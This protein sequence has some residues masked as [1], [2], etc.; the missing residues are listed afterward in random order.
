LLD[1]SAEDTETSC[2]SHLQAKAPELLKHHPLER[3]IESFDAQ[4]GYVGY[5]WIPPLV[6]SWC[7]DIQHRYGSDVLEEY[8]RLLLLT[9]VRNFDGRILDRRF[10]WS[11]IMLCRKY[12][13]GVVAQISKQ[14][15]GYYLHENDLFA[16]DLAVCR[17]KLVPC[18]A[19]LVD[20]HAGVPRRPLW[21]GG[22]SQAV[23]LSAFM[24]LKLG[25]WRPFF[26]MHMD[27]RLMLEF[28]PPGWT[29]CYR[30]ISELLEANPSV[31][32]V[33]GASWWFDPRLEEVS[34]RIAFLR[35]LPESHG[36]RV[37]RLGPDASST[38]NALA[39]SK[40]RRD[41]YE[42][43]QYTPINYILIWGRDDLI[44]WARAQPA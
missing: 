14:P 32:G 2:L 44:A 24:R 40:Q 8:H 26:G 10:P 9:L 20:V 15:R 6:T 31:R 28:N 22:L 19:Q 13:A 25:G 18:G 37:F 21:R 33:Y 39:N 35:T 17:Q 5:T 16:K 23:A 36:A 3:Y 27:L 42:R 43:G 41:L 38:Q 29:R 1:R 30:R 11:V 7:T 34:P 12:L 4:H